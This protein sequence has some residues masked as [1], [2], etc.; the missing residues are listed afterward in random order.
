MT[1][2]KLD[3]VENIGYSCNLLSKEQKLFTLK[4]M[5]GDDV[6]IVKENP[7][8]EM[9][10]FFSELQVFIE[11]LMKKYN[12]DTKYSFPKIIHSTKIKS[13]QFIKLLKIFLD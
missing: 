10:Q 11:G 13:R 12:F 3:T 7:Y 5:P 9:I 6:K 1:G 2:D 8:P 4:V